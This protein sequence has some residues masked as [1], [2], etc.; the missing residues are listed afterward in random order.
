MQISI[1]V[2]DYYILDAGWPWRRSPGADELITFTDWKDG[3]VNFFHAIKTAIA[4]V[5]GSI[6]L[7][8]NEINLETKSIYDTI[9]PDNEKADI[10]EFTRKMKNVKSA[11]E[12]NLIKQGARIADLAG[13]VAVKAIREGAKECDVAL[14]TTQAMIK[15]IS[16]TYPDAELMDSEYEQ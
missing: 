15:E 4:D 9:F 12:I 13:A 8:F 1:N 2:N 7:E 3:N 14:C 16:L 11:E 6:G 10:S 5:K